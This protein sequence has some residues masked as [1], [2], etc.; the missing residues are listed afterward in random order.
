MAPMKRLVKASEKQASSKQSTT[1]HK[2]KT[3]QA[4]AKESQESMKRVVPE[5]PISL[6]VEKKR[7][8]NVEEQAPIS[9]TT[10]IA[11][12][13]SQPGVK[14]YGIAFKLPARLHKSKLNP[15]AIAGPRLLSRATVKKCK[16]LQN[17]R[18]D[19]WVGRAIVKKYKDLQNGRSD[20]RYCRAKIALFAHWNLDLQGSGRTYYLAVPKEYQTYRFPS[21]PTCR[22]AV[23]FHNS[24]K[25]DRHLVGPKAYHTSSRWRVG[26][27]FCE[28]TA[29]YMGHAKRDLQAV[30]N[31]L[32]P[33][34][35]KYHAHLTSN[36]NLDRAID[37]I[38]NKLSK[39][40]GNLLASWIGKF[41]EIKTV[42]FCG[43]LIHH[44]LLH[45]VECEDK[46]VME[47]EFNG[48]G[49]RFDRKCFAMITGLNCDPAERAALSAF[50]DN[51]STTVQPRDYDAI[52]KSS[53]ESIL[54]SG[55]WLEVDAAL[56]YIRRRI[57]N[58]SQ[59]YD[60]RAIVTDCMFW[61][62]SEYEE[63]D[64]LSDT[65]DWENEMKDSPFDINNDNKHWLAA[66]V[67]IRNRAITLCD[68]NNAMSQDEF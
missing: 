23:F 22:F 1:N 41:F 37:V 4:T 33:D 18:S 57:I 3:R 25:S 66:K 50:I 44:L 67:D 13:Q 31:R 6:P 54:A 42:Q 58:S 52:E 59:M 27:P 30:V 55:A 5:T 26:P 8:G 32:V 60:Q 21:S 64:E 12:E 46:N 39:G 29:N 62:Q 43:G 14:P 35:K 61:K 10:N 34:D 38:K 20:L 36:S 2:Q 17:S 47:F 40:M 63:E 51:P 49:A 68:P 11:P 28:E 65:A 53:L 15:C 24:R 45:Q 56:H 7:R 16:D 19:L 9:T 48:T